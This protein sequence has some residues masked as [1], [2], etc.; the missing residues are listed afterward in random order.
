[1]F[2]YVSSL[3]WQAW[4]FNADQYS[5]LAKVNTSPMLLVSD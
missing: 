5:E 2:Y 1:M 3:L 4:S